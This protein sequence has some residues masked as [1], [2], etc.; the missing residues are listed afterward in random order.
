MF[1]PY[2]V[3]IGR[4]LST[5]TR[6]LHVFG[7]LPTYF[8]FSDIPTAFTIFLMTFWTTAA[9]PQLRGSKKRGPGRRWPRNRP[10]PQNGSS[11]LHRVDDVCPFGTGLAPEQAMQI[12]RAARLPPR[13][14]RLYAISTLQ[15]RFLFAPFRVRCT[16]YS[17]C[18]PPSIPLHAL[19]FS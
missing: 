16:N 17:C 14:L 8:H 10:S 11:S 3:E 19:L 12:S 1:T 7:L 18:P 13:R 5:R 2:T 4:S 9:K 6:C 15:F